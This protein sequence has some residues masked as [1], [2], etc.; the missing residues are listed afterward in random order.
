MP[1]TRSAGLSGGLFDQAFEV[2]QHRVPGLLG[3]RPFL[4]AARVVLA[5]GDFGAAGGRCEPEGDR[6]RVVRRAPVRVGEQPVRY[7]TDDL[8]F[9]AEGFALP[10]TAERDRAA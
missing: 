1:T 10:F 4:L 5:D 3:M 2:V 9:V 6:V 7:H 8:A